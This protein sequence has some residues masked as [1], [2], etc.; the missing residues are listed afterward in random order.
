MRS[1][2]LVVSSLGL[3]LLA[4]GSEVIASASLP[5][6]LESNQVERRSIS[7][8]HHGNSHAQPL[9]ILN[10][11][12]LLQYHQ[13]TPPSYYTID[14]ESDG[15][16][17]VSRHPGLMVT[18]AICMS[19]AFFVALP[20]GLNVHPALRNLRLMYHRHHFAVVEAPSSGHRLDFLLRSSYPWHL[21]IQGI[22]QGNTRYV[23]CSLCIIRLDIL[24]TF[25][26]Y[27]GSQP[28]KL[29]LDRWADSKAKAPS[30]A[31]RDT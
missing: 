29:G 15:D 10:E 9:L 27:E 17:A 2:C 23:R 6:P 1:P 5:N 12:E 20:L 25:T 18:H 28:L 13:P 7:G 22:P 21:F 31:N 14:W 16:V 8:H 4:L 30:T 24:I 26:R 3:C 11:T 19:L